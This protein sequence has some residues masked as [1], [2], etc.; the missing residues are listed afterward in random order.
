[1]KHLKP[2]M[3]HEELKA[4]LAY[5]P[6]AG[7]FIWKAKRR[8]KGSRLGDFAGT[9]DS[10]G[11]RQIKIKG[12]SYIAS[13][14]AWFLETGEWP[15][16]WIDHENRRRSDDA[17]ANL[18]RSTRA[19]NAGNRTVNRNST[20]RRK[21]VQPTKYGRF[22]AHCAKRYL[23]TFDTAEQAALAYE[24]EARKRYGEFFSSGEPI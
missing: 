12:R 24:Q 14:I 7:A 16:F 10:G 17:F 23:G 1:M 19:L 18:R 9:I 6:I 4:I 11:Y 2:P 5:D 20:T 8:G 3:P 15:S 21:G 22:T 13:K